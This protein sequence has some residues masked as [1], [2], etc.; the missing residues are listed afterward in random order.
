MSRAT[1]RSTVPRSVPSTNLAP[2]ADD[3]SPQQASRRSSTPKRKQQRSSQRR[4]NVRL[5]LLR[6]REKA[7]GRGRVQ[8][9]SKRSRMR[10]QRRQRRSRR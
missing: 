3:G 1:V 2:K 4:E 6:R 9:D 8:I 7:H 10:G 5:H